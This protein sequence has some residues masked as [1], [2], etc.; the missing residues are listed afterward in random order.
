MSSLDTEGSKA[1]PIKEATEAAEVDSRWLWIRRADPR[2]GKHKLDLKDLNLLNI[3]EGV[4]RLV[5]GINS[6]PN[7]RCAKGRKLDK[8]GRGLCR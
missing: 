4:S 8:R 6:L 7:G 1:S 2:V 5:G 3:S